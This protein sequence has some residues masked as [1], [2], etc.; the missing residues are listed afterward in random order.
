LEVFQPKALD[1]LDR[2]Q[3][4]SLKWGAP[5]K[6]IQNARRI[7][8]QGQGW[9]DQAPPLCARLPPTRND[10]TAQN[11]PLKKIFFQKPDAHLCRHGQIRRP[12]IGD[13]DDMGRGDDH[14]W[15]RVGRGSA[16]TPRHHIKQEMKGLFVGE[17]A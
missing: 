10:P 4:W 2:D 6:D 12:G 1:R 5:R 8:G 17:A 15:A 3:K 16:H 7:I 11:P 13:F 9:I 14:L